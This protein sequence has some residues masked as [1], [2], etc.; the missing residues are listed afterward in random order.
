MLN[1]LH[2]RGAKPG[3]EAV[4]RQVADHAVHSP[5]RRRH[6]VY[7]HAQQYKQYEQWFCPLAENFTQHKIDNQRIQIPEAGAG[8]QHSVNKLADG[9]GIS[10]VGGI[11]DVAFGRQP[12]V[13]PAKRQPLRHSPERQYPD[14]APDPFIN[15]GSPGHAVNI[16]ADQIPGNKEKH[17]HA[18]RRQIE[19][20][21]DPAFRQDLR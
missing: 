20:K 15:T 2:Q 6:E 5:P 19:V 14:N 18:K 11:V 3:A 1:P 13:E 9:P 8:R 16:A 4:V 21:V 17:R 10:G 12:V 7:R